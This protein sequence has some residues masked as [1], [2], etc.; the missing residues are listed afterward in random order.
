MNLDLTMYIYLNHLVK[1]LAYHQLI[2]LNKRV[3][4]KQAQIIL[5]QIITQTMN[6]VEKES[7]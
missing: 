4:V 7:L 5:P 6:L 1:F 2:Y 3:E